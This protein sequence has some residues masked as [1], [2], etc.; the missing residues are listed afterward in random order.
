MTETDFYKQ[1][2]ET[3]RKLTGITPDAASDTAIR[4]HT[5]AAE[6]ER[7]SARL[8]QA[9][10]QAFP[11]TAT[12]N[13]LDLHAQS[14]GM[15]RKQA[16]FAE[17]TIVFSR[18]GAKGARLIPK[19]TVCVTADGTEYVTTESITLADGE[20]Q[21]SAK[22]RAVH[23]GAN[24][25]AAVGTILRVRQ[26]MGLT[27][28][29]PE[30]FTGGRDAESD[31]ALRRRLL[32]AWSQLNTGINAAYYRQM[33]Q[34]LDGVQSAVCC[35]GELAGEI[36]VYLA[37]EDAKPMPDAFLLAAE[38]K[39]CELREPFATIQVQNAEILSTDI[40]VAVE[41]LPG[42]K[43]DAA[44]RLRQAMRAS[45]N[46]LAVGEKLTLA[47]LTRMI[48]KSGL[49]ENWK[50]LSPKQD[51]V[52]KNSQVLRAGAITIDSWEA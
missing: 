9:E 51:I 19:G 5:L 12:G 7:M 24:G 27:A 17:G 46:S 28:N 2:E 1:M 11:Q 25:N 42:T 38:K 37:G 8:E 40:S 18:A 45:I 14:R 10:T 3:Y 4:F 23:A 41:Y 34:S 35:E 36:I 30:P 50:F 32:D 49:A 13:T 26:L 15:A 44:D 31:Q 39:L 6:L 20:A 21:V 52:P 33:A 16:A 43:A 48:I 47:N 22:A 29:N